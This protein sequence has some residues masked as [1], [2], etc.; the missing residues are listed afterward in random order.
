LTLPLK[1]DTTFQIVNCRN[2]QAIDTDVNNYFIDPDFHYIVLNENGQE[3]NSII[4]ISDSGKIT[5][6]SKGTAIVLVSYDAMICHHT[7]NVGVSD[8]NTNGA[9]FSAIWP[10]NTGVFVVAV[11][12]PESGIKSNMLINQYWSSINGTDKVDSTQVDAEQDVLYYEADQGSFPFTFK[13]E[14]VSQVLI[15]TPA[16]SENSLLYNGFKA[17]SVTVNENESYTVHLSFGRNI[18]KM[19]GTDGSLKY[20]VITAKPVTW[21]VSGGTGE[22][23]TFLPGDEV[24]V[25]FNTLYHPCNKLSGIYNMSAGI[26]YTGQD[27]NFPLILG[28][29]QYTFASK[30]QTYTVTIPTDYSGN[31][32]VLTNGVIKVKG[33]GSYYGQHRNI[34]LQNGVAPNLNAS[35]RTAYFGSVPDIHI[36]MYNT[37]TG[38]N[39]VS[40]NNIAVY[41]NPFTDYIFIKSDKI[42]S[43]KIYNIQGQCVMQKQITQ[44]LNK[45]NAEF[46]EKGVYLI[47]IGN[48]TTKLMK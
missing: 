36:P 32:Y 6:K 30:A 17:D 3:D 48:E 38:T 1:A 10:E 39:I 37:Q 23:N 19:I 5:P 44:G 24:S 29:G 14:G 9:F 34:T 47:Q 11:D 12:E 2:W 18:I 25:L 33:F 42:Q 45:I 7:T 40:N 4:E 15:A 26:Q 31:E 22:N 35:V 16:I 20:Q 41:P 8:V 13:P 43:F 46:L 21:T 28:P 27:V